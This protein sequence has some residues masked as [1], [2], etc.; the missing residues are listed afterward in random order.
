[1]VL[2]RVL[3]NSSRPVAFTLQQYQVLTDTRD[4]EIMS[5]KLFILSLL[6]VAALSK[7]WYQ[8]GM[9]NNSMGN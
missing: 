8:G 2:Y 1:M 3:N 9:K 6:V 7:P 5:A 4:N